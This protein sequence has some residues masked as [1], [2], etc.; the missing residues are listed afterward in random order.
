MPSFY[1]FVNLKKFIDGLQNSLMPFSEPRPLDM[2]K[3]ESLIL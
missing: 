2:Y 1:L 3:S